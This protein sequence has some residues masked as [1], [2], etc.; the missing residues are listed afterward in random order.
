LAVAERK[1]L[2]RGS[3]MGGG[4][5]GGAPVTTDDAMRATVRTMRMLVW[6]MLAVFALLAVLVGVASATLVQVGAEA[7]SAMSIMSS[8]VSPQDVNR[9]ALNLASSTSNVEAA[10][11]LGLG[12]MG[13]VQLAVHNAALALNQTTTALESAN[14]VLNRLSSTGSLSIGVGR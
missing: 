7:T 11:A 13:D 12:A 10:T 5:M 2:L 14:G 4:A 8:H 3:G 9:M 6:G 1:G